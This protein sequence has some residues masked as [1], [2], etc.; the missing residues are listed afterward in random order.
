MFVSFFSSCRSSSPTSSYVARDRALYVATI[1][2]HVLRN[3]RGSMSLGMAMAMVQSD[4]TAPANQRPG[5]HLAIARPLKAK[6]TYTL[7]ALYV[8]AGF[9]LTVCFTDSLAEID[10]AQ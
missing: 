7:F 8:T 4:F 6:Y 9:H 10:L 1:L 2:T 3:T 5:C